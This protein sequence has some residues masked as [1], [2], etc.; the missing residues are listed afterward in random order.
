LRSRILLPRSAAEEALVAD[1]L[2]TARRQLSDAEWAAAY[3]SGR[4]VTPAQAVDL[5][6]AVDVAR[7]V[8]LA[9]G[10]DPTRS[11]DLS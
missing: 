7:S 8:D 10:V 11:T 4:D 9:R 2:S 5:L 1:W 3:E 6:R